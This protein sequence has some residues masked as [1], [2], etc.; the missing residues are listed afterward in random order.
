MTNAKTAPPFDFGALDLAALSDTP[1]EFEVEHPET[2][3]GL[4]VF[5][6]V[7]GAESEGFQQY[8]RAEGNALRRKAFEAQRK[9]KPDEPLTIEDEEETGLRALSAC[10][11]GWRTVIDGKSEPAIFVGGERMESN[12][13]NVLA[14]LRKFRWVRGQLNNATA[15]L[16]NYLGNSPPTSVITPKPSSN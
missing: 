1:F 7:I 15:T 8:L 4:G 2:G 10:V 13:A 12:P 9:G 3:D 6:A 16:A 5:V 14:W 11:K